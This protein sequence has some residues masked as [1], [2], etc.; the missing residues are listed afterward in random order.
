[1][2]EKQK[3]DYKGLLPLG[4]VV[5]LKDMDPKVFISGRIVCAEGDD[6]I[7]DYV[8]CIYPEGMGK[9]DEL[10]FFDREAVERLYFIGYQDEYEIAFRTEVLDKLGELEIVD[11]EMVEVESADE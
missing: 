7:Y 4:S 8:G 5:S 1:M 11:G 9:G 3:K 2:A 10:I 6:R